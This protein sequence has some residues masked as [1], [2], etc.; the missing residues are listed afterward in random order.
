MK[1]ICKTEIFLRGLVITD[2]GPSPA[3]IG[4]NKIL[5][6]VIELNIHQGQK[7]IYLHNHVQA[8]YLFLLAFESHTCCSFSCKIKLNY[9][10][11]ISSW[12]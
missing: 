7:E 11:L 6:K 3:V 4:Q 8:R 9:L 12:N 10:N 2:G 1:T 5:I